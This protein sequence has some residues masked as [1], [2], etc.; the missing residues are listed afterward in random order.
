MRILP[1]RR[2]DAPLPTHD[3]PRRGAPGTGRGLLQGKPALARPRPGADVYADRRARP[4]DGRALARRAATAAGP[5]AAGVVEARVHRGTRHVRPRVQQRLVRQGGRGQLS[6]KRPADRRRSVRR[7]GPR[8]RRD[9]DG[10]RAG[11]PPGSRRRLRARP[12]VRRDRRDH[13][14]HQHVESER[15]DRRRAAGEEGRRGPRSGTAA[16]PAS[17]TPGRCRTR[18]RRPFSTTTS[19][20]A[21]CSRGT[22]TSR[23]ASTP[24]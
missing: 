12:R 22:A 1:R 18:S 10:G 14:L 5:R 3:R 19:S 2:R 7:R 6:C 20:S 13:V 11:A 9:R 17:A 21:R 16:R 8:A 4:R 23:L 15:D 24:R